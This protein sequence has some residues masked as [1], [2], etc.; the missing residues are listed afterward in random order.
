MQFRKIVLMLLAFCSGISSALA[1]SPCDLRPQGGRVELPLPLHPLMVATF[2]RSCALLVT[3]S[4]GHEP[5]KGA[6]ALLKP[7]QGKLAVGSVLN[8]PTEPVGMVLTADESVA[9]VAGGSRIYFVDIGELLAGQTG[10]ILGVAEYDKGAGTVS[11]ALSRDERVLFTSDEEAGTVTLID[12]AAARASRFATAP[13]LGRIPVDWAPTIL[14]M[15]ADGKHVLL[16]VEAVRRQFKPP[17]LC[18]GHPGG[19]AV[20]PVGAILSI[21]VAQASALPARLAP[22]RSYA[23]CSPVRM[24]LSQD[25]RTAFVTNREEN[26]LRVMDVSKIL[27]GEP[28]AVVAKVPVGPAP[29]GVA[30]VDND[31][32]ALVSNSNRWASEQ[33]PQTVVVFDIAGDHRRKPVVLG[34]IPVGVFPRDL[35]VSRDGQTVIVSNFGSNSLTLLDVSKLRTLTSRAES[36]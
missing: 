31:R 35:A 14:K 10:A 33:T 11:L 23:G 5:A 27:H 17:I 34:K 21:Q 15:T 9:A 28:D 32:L 24:E 13:V 30:L 29:I 1:A 18:A 7:V 19:E 26:L 12:F 8:V 6:I 16:P 20:N 2:G 4:D 22:S 36:H 25:G 3:L